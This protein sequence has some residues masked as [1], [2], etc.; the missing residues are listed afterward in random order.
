MD[1]FQWLCN[2]GQNLDVVVCLILDWEFG[3]T[4]MLCDS[5]FVASY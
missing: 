4:R 3:G 1:V 2:L 5:S